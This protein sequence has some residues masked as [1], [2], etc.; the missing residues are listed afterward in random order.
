MNEAKPVASMRYSKSG[1]LEVTIKCIVGRKRINSKIYEDMLQDL[2]RF[3]SQLKHYQ[4]Y[5]QDN[6]SMNFVF[7][8]REARKI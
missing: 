7:E 5:T 2:S 3:W 8:R 6:H 1:H 4:T